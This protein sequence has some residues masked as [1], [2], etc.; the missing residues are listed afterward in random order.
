MG[1]VFGGAD[2]ETGWFHGPSLYTEVT[3]PD[4]WVSRRGSDVPLAGA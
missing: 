4:F 2:T 1:M 3:L